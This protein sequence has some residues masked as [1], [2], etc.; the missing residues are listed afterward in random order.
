M[1]EITKDIRRVFSSLAV[2]APFAYPIL[3]MPIEFRT[4]IKHYAATNGITFYCNPDKWKTLSFKQKMFVAMQEWLHIALQH[5]KRMQ[6]RQRKIW[7]AACA[8]ITS[9]I[10]VSDLKGHFHSYPGVYY[11]RSFSNKSVEQVYSI[12]L[13]KSKEE[14][15]SQENNKDKPQ[16]VSGKDAIDKLQQDDYD[17]MD[18]LFQMPSSVDDQKLIDNIIKAAVRAKSMKRGR[19]P[20]RYAEY[21]ETLKKSTIPWERI[22]FRF[23]KKALKGTSDRNPYKP[24][25][26][27]LPFDIIVPT[28][29]TNKI[30]KLVFIIDTS[31]SMKKEEF[32]YVCGHIERLGTIVDKCFVITADVQVQEKVR[33]KRIKKT[34]KDKAIQFKGRGGTDMT[35]AFKVAENMMPDLIILYSDMMLGKWPDKPKRSQ[36]IFIATED[37][38]VSESPYGIFIKVKNN[39][40]S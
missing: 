22:L 36:T 18:D 27:Y 34:L 17:G 20:G 14:K 9:D 19:L 33:V 29:E 32:E 28:E 4:D 25:P 5:P 6:G 11:D 16:M 38:S 2:I 13:E 12:L 26:K 37:S 40:R 7:T 24:D 1:K 21:I 8:F 15:T 3:M 31:A 35:E 10:I 30:G 23:A 39:G